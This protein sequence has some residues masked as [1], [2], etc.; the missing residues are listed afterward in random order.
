MSS[1]TAPVMASSSASE[2]FTVSA[3]LHR[4]MGASIASAA[5]WAMETLRGDFGKNT[6]PA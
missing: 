3:T 2:A 1:G 6:K 4:P 5:A